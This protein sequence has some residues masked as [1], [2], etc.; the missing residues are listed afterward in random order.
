MHRCRWCTRFARP[1][2]PDPRPQASLSKGQ[3]LDF[4]FR[5]NQRLNLEI[6]SRCAPFFRSSSSQ[7]NSDCQL[8]LLPT[9]VRL[10]PTTHPGER[11]LRTSLGPTQ[12]AA[13]RH[14]RR[15]EMVCP[16]ATSDR[17][18][19]LTPGKC[20]QLQA[21]THNSRRR[22]HRRNFE[23]GIQGSSHHHPTCT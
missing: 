13:R 12:H 10:A 4:G 7:Q 1:A 20:R 5:P 21:E 16:T 6:T 9:T 18:G 15:G 14:P 3:V 17:V 22:R 2:L 19:S 23:S 11:S 8:E